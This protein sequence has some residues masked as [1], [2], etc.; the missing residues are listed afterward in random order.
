MIL[1][2]LV[3]IIY[4]FHMVTINLPNMRVIMSAL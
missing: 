3:N 1:L 2:L 4:I